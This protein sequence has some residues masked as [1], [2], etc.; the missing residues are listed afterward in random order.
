M[1]Q[2]KGKG[3]DELESEIINQDLCC[4]CGACE[5][6]CPY[7]DVIKGRSIFI[8]NCDQ[9]EGDCY[10][11]C[12]M[13]PLNI[14]EMEKE[15]FGTEKEDPILGH[16]KKIKRGRAIDEKV[17]GESQYGGVVSALVKHLLEEE[18]VD[19][20]MLTS[21]TEDWK[22]KPVLVEEP[23]DVGKYTKTKYTANPIISR[24]NELRVEDGRIGLVGTPC[25][26]TA[27]RKMQIYEDLDFGP[28][29]GLFCTWGLKEEFLDY[30]EDIFDLKEV[31]KFDIPPPPAG[32][33]IIRSDG[34]VEEIPLDEVREYIMP[35]CNS[36][37]DM[38]S[39]FSDISVGQVEGRSGWNTMI[40]RSDYG[41]EIFETAKED[42]I[43]EI[44]E[45]D[46]KRL[47]HLKEASA[48]RKKR[49]LS[50]VNEGKINFEL[51]DED[52]DKIMEMEL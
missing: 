26:I 16:F 18:E 25:Q 10:K 35:T 8:A 6:I 38:T 4:G 13:S 30:I 28:M 45:L 48:G 7:I 9:E 50:E 47:N 36:C 3:P 29:I 51:K 1:N 21:R 23:E 44:E 22:P 19:G 42:K 52:R 43:I 32:K 17:R 46:E 5:N 41:E 34:E 27:A 31:E 39:E 33:M 20:F 2:F 49:I 11:F 40:I 24:L 14:S 12:P 37:L 15:I